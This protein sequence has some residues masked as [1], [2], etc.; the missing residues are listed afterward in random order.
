VDLDNLG[1][2]FCGGTR[3]CEGDLI[4]SSTYVPNFTAEEIYKNAHMRNTR[5]LVEGCTFSTSIEK[6]IFMMFK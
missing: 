3:S 6:I 1:A 4:S 5:A 2:D